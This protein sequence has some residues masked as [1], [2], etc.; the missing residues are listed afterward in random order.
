MKKIIALLFMGVFIVLLY[1]MPELY[2]SNSDQISTQL[3]QNFYDFM[4]S[5][6]LS[7]YNVRD[8][9]FL[10][11]KLMH[12]IIYSTICVIGI[13]IMKKICKRWWIAFLTAPVLPVLIAFAD[14]KIQTMTPGRSGMFI[15]VMLDCVGVGFG[16]FIMLIVA[17]TEDR[18][19]IRG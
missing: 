11:R 17:I 7:V 13:V 19:T 10:F 12:F 3:M 15:D 6:D 16:I 4:A 14:E 5:K 8:L 18:A 2:G 9:D 1:K